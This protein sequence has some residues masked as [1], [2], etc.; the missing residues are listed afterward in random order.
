MTDSYDGKYH[1]QSFFMLLGKTALASEAF[2]KFW[3][4][5]RYADSKRLVIV[6]YEIGFSQ[7]LL[8]GGLSLGALYPYRQL[9]ESVLSHTLTT[10]D[11]GNPVFHPGLDEDFKY[12]RNRMKL[13]RPLNPTHYFWKYLIAELGFPFI[14]RELL[15]KNPVGIPF[16]ISWRSVIERTSDYP[17][18]L[19]EDYL[20]QGTG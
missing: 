9:S 13:G 3:R 6:K 17:V 19:I 20:S 10:S 15:E 12:L 8:K 14:K 7:A 1:L 5:M 18:Q 2:A 11:S 16:L 4:N